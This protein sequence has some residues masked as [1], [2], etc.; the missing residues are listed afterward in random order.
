L[1]K[2]YPPQYGGQFPVGS[3]LPTYIDARLREFRVAFREN[4]QKETL[5]LSLKLSDLP[6]LAT[7]VCESEGIEEAELRSESR[8]KEVVKLRRIF[9][10]IAVRKMGYS[11]V[12]MWRGFL[13]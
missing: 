10:Q 12:G 9:C 1:L 5:R 3:L 8:K 11:P 4:S 2:V 6:S 13:A 7:K